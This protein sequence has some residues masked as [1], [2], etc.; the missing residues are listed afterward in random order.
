MNLQL[1][2]DHIRYFTREIVESGFKRDIDDY[3]SSLPNHQSNIITLRDI[4][5]KVLNVLK[6]IYQ[7]DLPDALQ[8]V[9]PN[10]DLR[11]F[12][13]SPHYA[14]IKK[15]VEDKQIELP[16]F[17]NQLNTYL[18]Q[19]KSQLTKNEKALVTVQN[20]IAPYISKEAKHITAEG[21]AIISIVFKERQTITSMKQ[22][23]KTLNA[24]NRTLPLYHQL[25]KSESPEDIQI[26]EVQNGS[27]DF[28]INLN[29]DVAL[30]LVDLFKIGFHVF[31]AYLGYKKMAKPF[32]DS[33]YGNKKL[34]KQEEERE[35][36]L[37][38]NIGTAIQSE[39]NKQ[40]K[41]ARKAD[42]KVNDTAV[43]KKVEQVTKLITSHIV[44]GNDIKLLAL[45]EKGEVKDGEEALPDEREALRER[46]MIARH[47]LSLLP[48]KEQQK[49]LQE[50]GQ[51][52]EEPEEEP[53]E[54]PK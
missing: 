32:I 31:A 1:M 13:E 48:V 27:I 16:E 26:I 5:T 12:T 23:T 33:Y 36:E 6:R 10:E 17:Y 54:E 21:I 9:L 7:S 42:K 35:K 11:P 2:S 37:L 15:T 19:L 29:L 14:N 45:P 43:A 39:I 20:F 28:V 44:K 24:W 50:Y 41:K 51:I 49:L 53:K 52:N 40:H 25:L 47:Q 8:S 22:F 4:A 46:S 30:N 3:L 38:D 34:I 18:T